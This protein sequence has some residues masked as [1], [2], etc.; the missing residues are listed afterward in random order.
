MEEAAGKR[1][2]AKR[3]YQAAVELDPHTPVALNNLVMMGLADK[4]DP[5]RLEL[6]AKRAV[7][8]LPNNGQVLD[9]LAQV[10]RVRKD[11]PGALASAQQAVK[12]DPKDAGLLA[13]LAEMQQ[14]NGDRVAAKASAD[15]VL[16]MQPQGEA[17]VRARA[18]LGR[19]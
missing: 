16:R 7:K 18:V 4:D 6:M 11:K 17:A 3:R 5:A 9:T 10:Q 19:L 8:A 2:E 14:W 12:I 13:T 1:T 15:E